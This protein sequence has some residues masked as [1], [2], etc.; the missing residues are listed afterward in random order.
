MPEAAPCATARQRAANGGAGAGASDALT[1][2]VH[3]PPLHAP[4]SL[5][6]RAHLSID[7]H[8]V[9]VNWPVTTSEYDC[10]PATRAPDTD[11]P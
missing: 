3:L 10:M 11:T 8:G 6:L 1:E 5:Q 7:V 2:H 4:A 9:V